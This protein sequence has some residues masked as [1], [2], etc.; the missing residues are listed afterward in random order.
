[1][2]EVRLEHVSYRSPPVRTRE[3]LHWLLKSGASV[4]RETYTIDLNTE[5]R[6]IRANAAEPSALVTPTLARKLHRW[7]LYVALAQWTLPSI[8]KGIQE[9]A[10]VW[11]GQPCREGHAGRWVAPC[12]RP[13]ASGGLDA[14]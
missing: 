14:E 9:R 13:L 11:A 5:L 12:G 4:P 1:M 6:P 3:H 8:Q 2:L 10:G 7:A